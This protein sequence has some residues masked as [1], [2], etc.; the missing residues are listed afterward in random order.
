MIANLPHFMLGNILDLFGVLLASIFISVFSTLVIDKKRII[1]KVQARVLDLR[2]E[3]YDDIRNFIKDQTEIKMFPENCKLIKENLQISNLSLEGNNNCCSSYGISTPEKIKGALFKL[4]NLSMNGLYILDDDV[5]GMILQVKIYIKNLD[6]FNIILNGYYDTKKQPTDEELK[7]IG[8]FY[9][10]HLSILLNNEYQTMIKKL[11]KLI[12]EKSSKPKFEHKE[13]DYR[14][15]K[16]R[17]NLQTKA[18]EKTILMNRFPHLIHGLASLYSAHFNETE[19]ERSNTIK[20]F[21]EY[22][23]DIAKWNIS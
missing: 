18:L 14:K 4:E 19:E 10:H 11:Q 13:K 15:V 12:I 8:K 22:T 20:S 2:L 3:Q 23:M 9:F 21:L 16:T 7:E 1:R 5:L 6:F 17:Q